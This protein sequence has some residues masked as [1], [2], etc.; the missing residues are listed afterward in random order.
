MDVKL[1]TAI[2]TIMNECSSHD[3]CGSCPFYEDCSVGVTCELAQERVPAQWNILPADESAA[4][5][6]RSYDAVKHPSHYCKN[7]LEC[8]D[9]IKAEMTPEQYKGYLYGNVLKYMWRWQD[10]NGLEDLKKAG[11][12]LE[13]LQEE[14][15]K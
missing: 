10:K 2:K 6:L 3:S 8:I 9:V 4:N 13:W 1:K 15:G 5:P 14:A 7:G 12:Y 11:Q